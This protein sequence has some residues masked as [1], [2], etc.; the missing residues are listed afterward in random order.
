[1]EHTEFSY[2]RAPP[3]H[4]QQ[5]VADFGPKESLILHHYNKDKKNERRNN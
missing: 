3:G 5:D 4:S 1:M 2:S